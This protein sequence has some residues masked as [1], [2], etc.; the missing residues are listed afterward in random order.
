LNPGRAGYNAEAAKAS[1]EKTRTFLARYLRA[2]P[3][4]QD[5]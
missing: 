3:E 1:M 2:E 4:K 5:I